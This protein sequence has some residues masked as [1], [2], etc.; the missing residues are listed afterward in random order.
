M[1]KF[2]VV[3]VIAAVAIFGFMLVASLVNYQEG[4]VH[5]ALVRVSLDDLIKDSDAIAIAKVLDRG[6]SFSQL[7]PSGKVTHTFSDVT[8][9]IEQDLAGT[10]NGQN[11]IK[12]R[13]MPNIDAAPEFQQEERVLL[14]LVKGQPGDVEGENWV[15]LGMFQGKF[16]LK[17][18][19]AW[20]QNYPEG[21]DEATLVA[22]IKSNRGR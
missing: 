1:N 7:S 6:E 5:V 4:R 9:Q 8:L 2:L 12:V 21:I 20:N 11:R 19:K 3:G 18:G 22:K 16:E 17:S 15:V 10:L 14:F 13:I